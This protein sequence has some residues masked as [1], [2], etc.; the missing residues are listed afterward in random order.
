MRIPLR[1]V[2]EQPTLGAL[3]ISIAGAMASAEAP[4]D[5]LQMLAEIQRLSDAEAR[6]RLVLESRVGSNGVPPVR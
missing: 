6:D 2:F 3:A 1:E 4:A 5:V